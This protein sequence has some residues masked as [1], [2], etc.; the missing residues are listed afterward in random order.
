MNGTHTHFSFSNV[1][2]EDEF[3]RNITNEFLSR[4]SVEPLVASEMALDLLEIL[5]LTPCNLDEVRSYLT[6]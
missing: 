5:S 2:S 1:L 4:Y 3:V 6:L